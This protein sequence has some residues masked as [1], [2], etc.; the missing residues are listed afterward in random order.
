MVNSITPA[1]SLPVPNLGWGYFVTFGEFRI[2]TG[3]ETVQT[4]NIWNTQKPRNGKNLSRLSS[5]RSSL[6]VLIM[7]KRRN[8]E[9]R[10]PQIMM[11]S[12][13]T[14]WRA[15]WWPEKARVMIASTTKLVPPA[16]SEQRINN[17]T[18]EFVDVKIYL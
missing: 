8:P 5:K 2:V 13:S 18:N 6:P 1:M 10:A 3:S 12:E 17:G 11:K 14:I 7:R 4:Q 9:S 16:K 15:L